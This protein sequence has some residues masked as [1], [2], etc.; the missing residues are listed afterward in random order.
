MPEGPEIW[1]TCQ[2]LMSYEGMKLYS[3]EPWAEMDNMIKYSS[4]PL[5]PECPWLLYKL[6]CH[7]KRILFHFQLEGFQMILVI[8]FG[9]TGMLF[10]EK[11]EHCR[12]QLD[13]GSRKLFYCD[14]RQIGNCAYWARDYLPCGF[15]MV[16]RD[17]YWTE[18]LGYLNDHPR[19]NIAAFL[20]NQHIFPGIGNYLKSEILYQAR[21]H[22]DKSCSELTKRQRKNLYLAVHNIPRQSAEMGGFT[23]ESFKLPTGEMGGYKPLIYRGRFGPRK[24]PQGHDIQSKVQQGRKTHYC[25]ICQT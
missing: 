13:F 4:K 24:C 18:W 5:T 19:M 17:M 10:P 1:N 2:S 15:D 3:Y 9:M 16:R 12:G 22:P 6:D 20:M 23:L 7:G 8:G 25:A 21:V 11:I 14:P